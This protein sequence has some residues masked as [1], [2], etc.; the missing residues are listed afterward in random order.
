MLCLYKT[1]DWTNLNRIILICA[2]RSWALEIFESLNNNEKLKENFDF[3]LVKDHH[4]LIKLITSLGNIDII[5][6]IGWSWLVPGEITE[7]YFV[8]GL[9]PS[10]LPEFAGGSPIQNQILNGIVDSKLTLFKFTNEI[11]CGPIISKAD[12]SLEGH[13]DAIFERLAKIGLNIIIEFLVQY[14]FYKLTVVTQPTTIWKRI[15]PEQSKMNSE[16]FLNLPLREIYNFIRCREDPYPNAFIEDETGRLEF[17]VVDF[18]PKNF[19]TN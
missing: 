10:N 6:C 19:N 13:I 1:I 14:P 12:L 18:F 9:H 8:C 4:T 11:D 3:I 15:K 5:I 2:Y 7:K 16:D 17:K